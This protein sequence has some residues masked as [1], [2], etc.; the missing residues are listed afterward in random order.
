MTTL[1]LSNFSDIQLPCSLFRL[2]QF[3]NKL[4]SN[5]HFCKISWVICDTGRVT[6]YEGLIVASITQIT[7]RGYLLYETLIFMKSFTLMV[8]HR[9]RRHTEE[10]DNENFRCNVIVPEISR[11]AIPACMPN[12]RE[13]VYGFT[14]RLFF[15]VSTFLL[16]QPPSR[17]PCLFLSRSLRHERS[18]IN[19]VRMHAST[20][21]V[22]RKLAPYTSIQIRHPA[23]CTYSTYLPFCCYL[24]FIF[25]FLPFT[26]NCPR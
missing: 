13:Y 1:A 25:P 4:T 10:R 15:A 14:F 22:L 2:H 7:P 3:E 18:R 20:C 21:R 16:S 19:G 24:H 6:V 5:C 8:P 17:S 23:T 11:R 26:Y 9:W 12:C